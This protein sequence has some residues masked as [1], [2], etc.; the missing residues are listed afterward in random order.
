MNV[1]EYTE[2]INRVEKDGFP[3]LD[4]KELREKCVKI[5]RDGNP[6]ERGNS[7]G[8]R[9]TVVSWA[10]DTNMASWCARRQSGTFY[11]A[12]DIPRDDFNLVLGTLMFEC[13][14]VTCKESNGC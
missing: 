9:C 8:V 10:T 6:T 2:T 12:K 14:S 7:K 1:N 3:I 5:I 11:L 13:S 4:N